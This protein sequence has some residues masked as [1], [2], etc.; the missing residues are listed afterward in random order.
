[1]NLR[2]LN[3]NAPVIWFITRAW[4][5]MCGFQLLP[6]PQA[7]S[8]FSDVRLY[9]WWASN[10][11]DGHFPIND[12]MWQYPPLAALVFFIAFCISANMVGFVS[13]ALA[14]DAGMY[15][16]LR[17]VARKSPNPRSSAEL[18]WAAAPMAIGPILLGRFDVFPTCAAVCAV[19]AMRTPMK[20][21]VYLALGTLL[22]A[23]PILG[24]IGVPRRLHARVGAAY[25]IALGC[26]LGLLH[27]W[28]PG[29]LGFLVG[30]RDRGLQIESVGALP[31]MWKN[32][33]PGHVHVK[34]R[35]GAIEVMSQHTALISV[36]L[37]SVG[38]LTIGLLIV[39][40]MQG[41]LESIPLPDVFLLV[42]L[43]SMV[44]SR[45]LSPQYN[46]W[47]LGLLATCAFLPAP[48]F[49]II[50]AL[51]FASSFLGQ[52]LY[53]WLYVSFQS[54]DV[55]ATLVQTFRVITLIAATAI[56]WRSVHRRS[57][58]RRSSV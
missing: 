37:T 45:V 9:D 39:W 10:M 41:R 29:S 52:L 47:V 43:L 40:R 26:G 44:T 24:L 38:V 32:A 16:A 55:F 31:Y 42:V 7:D 17:R 33:G 57:L 15:L 21:G 8:L 54:G 51:L 2:N 27:M 1:M 6:Y 22:K 11:V 25:A 13:L 4:V 18:I 56:L 34:F 53:P 3:R 58:P 35:Y 28:W 36:V 46:I 14:V 49:P 20:S 19:L 48:E 5:I 23:W 12:P 50:A 30:Q